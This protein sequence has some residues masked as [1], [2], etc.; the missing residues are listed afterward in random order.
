MTAGHSHAR[1]APESARLRR[2]A[3]LVIAPIAV[4]TIAAMVWLWPS[5]DVAG[6]EELAGEQV[7]GRIVSIEAQP[8]EEELTEDTNGCGTAQ[9][10]LDSGPEEGRTI[11]VD[12]P[13]GSGAP[14]I[15][16][17]DAVVVLVSDT[18]EGDL[19][20]VV[21][22]QRGSEM[23]VLV[24]V[25]VLAL[26]AFGRWRGLSAVGGLVVTFGILLWFIVPA[27][28]AGESPV[29]VALVGS[30]AIMVSV[31]Y[32][33]HGL[34]LATTVAVLGTTASFALT[35]LLAAVS[36]AALHLTGVTD[37]LSMAV[38]STYDVDMRGLLL[39]G[40]VIGT[41]GVLDDIT[42]TQAA[43]VDELARANPDYGTL[44]LYRAATRV[45]RA[46]IASVVNTIILAYA[47]SSLPVLVLVVADNGSLAEVLT[48]Q[49]LAQ[50]IVRS[51]VGTLGLI[52]AV[53]ITTGLAAVALR[54]PQEEVS[55]A[56]A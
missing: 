24:L 43:T 48:D 3:V 37:D 42:V 4:L 2:I 28:L 12:L 32:L 51:L 6:A 14:T 10:R 20:S 46:H 27:I 8:C 22:H 53:P 9:V 13:N 11:E 31:L 21:D 45:G 23:W 15:A 7:D 5:G 29:L 54:R 52:A 30:A 56:R 47:G 33:T 38:G 41:L 25:S 55:A 17:G 1:P 44:Q 39:A 18:P 19:Y 40:I 35:G 34:T 26:L 16:D 36:V 49:F 50:E